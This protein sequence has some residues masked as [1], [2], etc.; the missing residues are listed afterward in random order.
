[1]FA[2]GFLRPVSWANVARDRSQVAPGFAQLWRGLDMAIVCLGGEYVEV[3]T[4][5]RTSY[6]LAPA[7]SPCRI[8]GVVLPL[9]TS[10]GGARFRLNSPF[11]VNRWSL[12]TCCVNNTSGLTRRRAVTLYSAAGPTARVCFEVGDGTGVAYLRAAIITG[13]QNQGLETGTSPAG[14]VWAI[15]QTFEVDTWKGY[16]DGPQYFSVTGTAP[17]Q[18]D[19]IDIGN[20]STSGFPWEGWVGPTYV[21]NRVVTPEESRLL[22]LD[23]YGPLRTERAPGLAQALAQQLLFFRRWR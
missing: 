13:G 1:M 8:G 18:P 10:T 23:P 5:Q 11:D 6:D 2:D 7:F 17:T 4:G 9:F 19:S 21:W 20:S 12:F 22:A 14:R 16:I 15:L 3:I